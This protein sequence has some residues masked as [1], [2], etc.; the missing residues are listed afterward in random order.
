[1]R[2]PR[3]GFLVVLVVL[4]LGAAA[5]GHTVGSRSTSALPSASPSSG[6]R[7]AAPGLSGGADSSVAAPPVASGAGTT[8]ARTIGA[9]VAPA[10]ADIV[11]N[12]SL[13]VRLRNAAGLR[14]SYRAIT[15]LATD[16]GGFVSRSTLNDGARPTA[17][18]TVRV[19]NADVEALIARIGGM[20]TVTT[21]TLSGQDVTGQ[22]VDLSV[23]IT[24]L[25]SEEGAVRQ[26][27]SRTGSVANILTVQQQLFQLQDE[28]QELTAQSASLHNR[29][30][31]ATVDV[32]LSTRG[33][34]PAPHHRPHHPSTLSRFW[35]LTTSHS[36]ALVRGVVLAIGWS[37]P[38]LVLLTLA[39]AVALVLRRRHR[40]P[41]PAAGG[42]VGDAD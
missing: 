4:T 16:A 22:V 2:T 18:L 31:Y 24:N 21:Q 8:Q 36:V 42:P 27:L 19:P 35:H 13:A 10:A 6:V 14:S 39:G 34:A 29:V 12:G 20:G 17:S 33:P 15:T 37:A 5:C 25:T 30:Q 38:G 7:G 40:H 3:A 32:S 11:E 28:V 9:T 23:E 26:L 41:V 1:M